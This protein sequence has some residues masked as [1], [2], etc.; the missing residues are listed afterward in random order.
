VPNTVCHQQ[1]ERQVLPSTWPAAHGYGTAQ[2]KHIYQLKQFHRERKTKQ[3]KLGLTATLK[4]E[5]RVFLQF[6]DGI[7]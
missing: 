1:S 7:L 2:V 5:K 6:E 4:Q 3:N